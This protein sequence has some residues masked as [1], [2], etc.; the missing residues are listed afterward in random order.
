MM[1]NKQTDDT[2]QNNERACCVPD[3]SQRTDKQVNASPSHHDAYYLDPTLHCQLLWLEVTVREHIAMYPEVHVPEPPSEV[4]NCLACCCLRSLD[5][6]RRFP[7][8]LKE[9]EVLLTLERLL[10][11]F[12]DQTAHPVP[13]TH[14]V[15]QGQPGVNS[16]GEET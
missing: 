6:R 8:V 15:Q 16:G 7:P 3:A 9:R 5:E 11:L 12:P 1:N 13:A 2:T 14:V 10:E 4:C